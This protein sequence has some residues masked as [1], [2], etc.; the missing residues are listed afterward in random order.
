MPTEKRA[1]NSAGLRKS[2]QFPVCL[3]TLNDGNTIHQRDKRTDT[4]RQQRPRLRIAR[5][6]IVTQNTLKCPISRAK[7]QNCSGRGTA[8]P[9]TPPKW[10]VDTPPHTLP[11]RGL[12]HLATP[13][14]FPEI[15]DPPLV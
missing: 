9:Q 11:P 1:C 4:G 8:P 3:K 15:L 10:V 7:F 6:R 2:S 13:A 14:P 12:R 5:G